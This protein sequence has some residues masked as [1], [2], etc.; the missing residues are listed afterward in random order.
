MVPANMTAF[1]RGV[2][3]VRSK[4]DFLV[5]ASVVQ[6]FFVFSAAPVYPDQPLNVFSS[7]HWVR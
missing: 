3:R 6:R 4:T 1:F 2:K 5:V 7:I